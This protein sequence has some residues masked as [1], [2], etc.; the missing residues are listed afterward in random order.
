MLGDALEEIIKIN[1]EERAALRH[2]Q[3]PNWLT[4]KMSLIGYPFAGKKEQAEMIRKKFNLDVFVMDALVQE[5]ID[6]A[7]EHP[8]PIE[9]PAKEE[10]KS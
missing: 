4:V 5:A 2:P 8:E 6:F 3:T 7:A 10:S 1:F 9:A